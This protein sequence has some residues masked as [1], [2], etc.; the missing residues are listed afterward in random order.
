MS[1]NLPGIFRMIGYAEGV[2]YLVL[3]CIAMPLKYIFDYHMVVTIV[4]GLH[5]GLFILYIL[6]ALIMTVV[7]RW[8]IIKT[9][10]AALASV[11][12]FGPFIF[13]AKFVN[14]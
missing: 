5:G 7:Y 8:R 9:L 12:P 4:G 13:D 1:K 3:L 2:S 10:L 14:N 11:I 6:G